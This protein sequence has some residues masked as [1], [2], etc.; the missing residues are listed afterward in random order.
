MDTVDTAL[1]INRTPDVIAAEINSIK[2]QTRTM[3]LNNSIEIG[4]RLTEAK[5]LI[6]HGEWG[7]W[8]ETSVEYSQSTATNLMRIYDEYGSDQFAL[9]GD[10]QAKS[11]ALA[12][13]SYTQAVA[14]LGVPAEE[15]EEFIQEHDVENISTRELQQLI[16]EKAELAEKL[17]DAL[18]EA[19]TVSESYDRLEKVN[20]QH[21][22][23]SQRLDKELKKIKEQLKNAQDSG[24]DEE[25]NEL[26]SSLEDKAKELEESKQKI[27][28]LTEQLKEKPIDVSGTVEKIPDEVE[29]ELNTLRKNKDSVAAVQKYTVYFNVLVNGFK[30][31][32]GSLEDIQDQ[33]VR[34]Q[35]KGAVIRLLD[36][37]GEALNHG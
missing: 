5:S 29:A 34:E 4:R 14:L 31:L 22:N 1:E 13:L 16:K 37:M 15:R 26:Q 25:V 19:K 18:D 7:K 36:K 10:H 33:E 12:N 35:Y 28:E 9:F 3:I 20:T 11:Q 30:D 32:L 23:E 21:Y 2:N 8:L 17:K 27:E 24:N 6:Q